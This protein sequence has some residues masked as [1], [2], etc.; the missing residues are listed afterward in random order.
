MVAT[1]Q[2]GGDCGALVMPR[3][4]DSV[5]GDPGGGQGGPVRRTSQT[6]ERD[7]LGDFMGFAVIV[8]GGLYVLAN[9]RDMP[10]WVRV[11]F[12]VFAG[13]FILAAPFWCYVG[14]RHTQRLIF[15][16]AYAR[17]EARCEEKERRRWERTTRKL[18]ERA[19]LNSAV[20]PWLQNMLW[21]IAFMLALLV[22]HFVFRLI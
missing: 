7:L 6:K 9:W 17:Y 16:K 3:R 2:R 4:E 12:V 19:A 15:P 14:F 8:G 11:V 10:E 22:G 20:H 13:M 18:E 21:F 5:W 1:P